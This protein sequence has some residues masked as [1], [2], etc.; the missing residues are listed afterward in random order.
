MGKVKQAYQD[1]LEGDRSVWTEDPSIL[2]APPP[3]QR[4]NLHRF[5][6]RFSRGLAYAEFAHRMQERKGSDVPYIGHLLGVASIV[7]DHGGTEDEAIGALLHD[8]AEDQGGEARLADIHR[9]FGEEV[10]AIVAGCSDSLEADPTRKQHWPKRKGAYLAHL[11]K[12]PN[13]SV[14]FVSAADKAHNLRSMLAD[15]RV[16]GKIFGRDSLRGGRGAFVT[17]VLCSLSTKNRDLIRE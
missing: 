4:A 17:I 5:G 3:W 8:A 16:V 2:P 12:D 9:E 7:I 1:F 11:A 6:S 13:N 15:Y 14:V 10:S